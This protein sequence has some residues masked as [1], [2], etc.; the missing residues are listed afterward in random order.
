MRR[1]TLN[2][3]I[4]PLPAKELEKLH[5]AFST[6]F[7]SIAS[8]PSLPKKIYVQFHIEHCQLPPLLLKI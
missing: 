7:M 6:K 3:S 8:S 5:A 1:F 4:T 2:V